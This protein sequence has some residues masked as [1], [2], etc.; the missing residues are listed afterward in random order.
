MGGRM[1]WEGGRRLAS[2]PR[3]RLKELEMQ[4]GDMMPDF[5]R[6]L[7]SLGI[8]APGA[9]AMLPTERSEHG[10]GQL[11]HGGEEWGSTDEFHDARHHA[12]YQ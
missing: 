11:L 4:L 6:S 7:L 5:R 12:G 8:N 10:G 3:D 9:I 2:K 1:S